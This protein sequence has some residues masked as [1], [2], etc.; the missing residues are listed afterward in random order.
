MVE[1]DRLIFLDMQ[2]LEAQRAATAHDS[3]TSF[4]IVKRLAGK[5]ECRQ[6]H[7]VRRKDEQIT[8]PE[9]QGQ[10]RWQERFADVFNGAVVGMTD[11]QPGVIDPPRGSSSFQHSPE[12]TR[13][14]VASL[15]HN[16]GTGRDGISA[17][18]LQAGGAALAV[19]LHDIQKRVVQSEQWLVA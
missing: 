7:P 6:P 2:A 15:K 8:D 1:R 16:R 5:S 3:R 14:A 4:A 11:V 10:L 9:H 18:L 17:E 13:K 12:I 19:K